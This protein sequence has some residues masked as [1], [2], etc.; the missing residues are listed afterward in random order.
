M[1]NIGV[2]AAGSEQYYLGSV[3]RGVEDYYLGGEVPGRW[4]GRGA[5]LLALRRGRRRRPRRR[6]GRP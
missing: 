3:A 4:L 1:L 2:L 5:D 6:A